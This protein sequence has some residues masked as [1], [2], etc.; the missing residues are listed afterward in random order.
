MLARQQVVVNVEP[1]ASQIKV[2]AD[3]QSRDRRPADQPNHRHRQ[4]TRQP[5]AEVERDRRNR[6][7]DYQG[8]DQQGQP[9]LPS[10]LLEYRQQGGIAPAEQTARKTAQP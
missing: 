2:G 8:D 7:G 1:E 4:Q 6:K 9:A 10:G 3:M 5:L